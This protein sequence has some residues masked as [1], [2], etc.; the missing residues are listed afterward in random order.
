MSKKTNKLFQ[1]AISKNINNIIDINNRYKEYGYK[2]YLVDN[3]IEIIYNKSIYSV[4]VIQ[5]KDEF[6]WCL[7]YRKK[8]LVKTKITDS[9]EIII[10]TIYKNEK[11]Y[12]KEGFYE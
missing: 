4:E 3:S 6:Y 12:Q 7:M 5:N 10:Q 9:F 11:L 2:L 8:N 1:F